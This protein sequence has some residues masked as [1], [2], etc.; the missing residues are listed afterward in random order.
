MKETRAENTTSLCVG[1]NH[2]SWAEQLLAALFTLRTRTNLTTAKTLARVLQG[3]DLPLS[4]EFTIGA[5]EC[6]SSPVDGEEREEQR[7][8]EVCESQEYANG[9]P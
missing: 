6:A 1:E 9:N 5:R 4:S 3:H 7:E 2:T 8:R